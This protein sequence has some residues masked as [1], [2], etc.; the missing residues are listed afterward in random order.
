MVR[1]PQ[2][3]RF[4]KFAIKTNGEEKREKISSY[5]EAIKQATEERYKHLEGLSSTERTTIEI[6]AQIYVDSITKMT[7]KK[8]LENY[9]KRKD[10]ETK[11]I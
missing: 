11:E 5:A 2:C 6:M 3:F 9:L 7:N 4:I 8:S 10:N 1:A